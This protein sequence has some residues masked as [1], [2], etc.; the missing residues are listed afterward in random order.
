MKP[1]PYSEN[2]EN[3]YQNSPCGFLSIHIDGTII[4]VNDTLLQW[5]NF[6]REEV[7]F[8]KTF[9]E[10]LSTGGKIYFQTHLIPL[11]EMQGKFH[12]ISVDLRGKHSIQIPTLINAKMVKEDG[13]KTI[14]RLSILDITQ[15][16]QYEKELLLARKE[17]E[18][19]AKKL[20]QINEELERFAN[21]ASHDLQAPL[22]TLSG[23]FYLLEKKGL[24]KESDESEELLSMVKKNTKYMR[25]MIRDLL[26]YS[27]M[28][29]DKEFKPVSLNEALEKAI[30]LLSDK[31]KSNNAVITSSDLPVV[32]GVE[33]QF[34]RLFQ[35]LLSNAIKYRSDDD[36]EISIESEKRGEFYVIRVEDNGMGIEPKHKDKIFEFM[37]R[38]HSNDEIE[39]TGIGLSSCKRIVENHGGE[40]GVESDAGKGSTF[41]FTIP[42]RYGESFDS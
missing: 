4:N 13:E 15:R 26:E 25:A 7:V 8:E 12:E 16:K 29:V 9:Q 28:D 14:C 35:N 27:R 5:L 19:K 22:N 36:P 17:A 30:E 33:T 20:E 3:F 34:V 11:L 42:V 39:G 1:D 6:E 18:E 38:L 41:Y 40:M 31:I 23:V 32:K 2:F 24:I 10:L 37:E 21:R